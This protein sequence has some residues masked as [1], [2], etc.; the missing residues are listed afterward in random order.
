MS[1]LL[2]VN[3]INSHYQVEYLGLLCEVGPLCL[4]AKGVPAILFSQLGRKCPAPRIPC[5]ACNLAI[6]SF[7]TSAVSEYRSMNPQVQAVPVVP[8][9]FRLVRLVLDFNFES[10]LNRLRGLI[11]NHLAKLI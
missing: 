2:L 1:A 5:T 8:T 4:L 11:P 3:R 7:C 6:P 9:M 10:I